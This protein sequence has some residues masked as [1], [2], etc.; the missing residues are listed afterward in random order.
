MANRLRA[1]IVTR[2]SCAESL[3][4]VDGTWNGKLGASIR[5]NCELAHK[6][7]QAVRTAPQLE[8]CAPVAMNIVCIAY[9]SLRADIND[10]IVME[11][12]TRGIAAPSTTVINGRTVIRVC[13]T[14]HRTTEPDI[15]LLLAE[16]LRIGREL[17]N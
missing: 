16:I 5:Q 12:Q 7:G 9:K 4:A 15:E 6:L 10:E 8:L 2:L 13:I 3:D 1:G 11:L 17:S 14:N